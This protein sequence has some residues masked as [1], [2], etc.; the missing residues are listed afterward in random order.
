MAAY[1]NLHWIPTLFSAKE[2]KKVL[3]KEEVILDLRV[4]CLFGRGSDVFVNLPNGSGKS[5][6]YS[7][8][9]GVFDKPR[10]LPCLPTMIVVRP[11]V[12]LMRDQVWTMTERNNHAAYQGRIQGGSGG[13]G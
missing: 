4:T 13:S 2:M 10:R 8:L 5:L 7:L 1:R 9:P 6:Y 12:A 11:L 3:A